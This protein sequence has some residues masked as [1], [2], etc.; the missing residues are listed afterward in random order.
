MAAPE[1]EQI[2][3]ENAEHVDA[4]LEADGPR[5]LQEFNTTLYGNIPGEFAR[6]MDLSKGE[7]VHVAYNRRGSAVV[8]GPAIIIRRWEEDE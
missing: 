3:L 6:D 5:R 4:L 8:D 1:P 7:A 2:R